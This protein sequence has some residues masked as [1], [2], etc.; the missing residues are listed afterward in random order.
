MLII[1]LGASGSG[2]TTIEKKLETAGVHRLRS[3]TTRAKKNGEPEDAY[4]FVKKDEFK[5]ADIV[6]SVLYK[7]NFFGLSR[8]ELEV[9]RV[10]DCVVTLD[11]NGAQQIKNVFPLA[12]TIYIDCP[13]YQLEK[14]LPAQE[15]SQKQIKMLEQIE[16]DSRCAEDCEYIVRNYDGQ[17]DEAS[18]RILEIYREHKKLIK[19]GDCE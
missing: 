1:L 14:R 12:I 10:Q 11:W 9:A 4:Y 5:K 7:N 6:E 3:H 17:L 13:L 18:A 19:G 16:L 2:K 15:D 8:H